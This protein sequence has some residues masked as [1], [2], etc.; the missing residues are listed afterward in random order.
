MLGLQFLFTKTFPPYT[1]SMRPSDCWPIIPLA[2]TV[3]ASH[4]VAAWSVWACALLRQ[5]IR[6]VSRMHCSC[7]QYV[8]VRLCG[9]RLVQSWVRG[10]GHYKARV[11]SVRYERWHAGAGDWE[12]NNNFGTMILTPKTLLMAPNP[13]YTIHTIN[14]QSIHLTLNLPDHLTDQQSPHSNRCLFTLCR[15]VTAD[16]SAS[17]RAQ[18]WFVS[19]ISS[20]SQYV[21]VWQGGHLV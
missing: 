2:T 3:T 8:T 17:A 14:T 18:W 5:V 7:S 13:N 9:H 19:H 21:T 12:T 11:V 10:G 16:Q 20:C 1:L 15:G 4:A 6:S